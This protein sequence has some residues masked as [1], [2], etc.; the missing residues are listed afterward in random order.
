VA[1]WSIFVFILMTRP[2]DHVGVVQGWISGSSRRKL[3]PGRYLISSALFMCCVVLQE[4]NDNCQKRP[5]LIQ[6]LQKDMR[7]MYPG[8]QP[9]MRSMPAYIGQQ[10]TRPAFKL[11]SCCLQQLHTAKSCSDAALPASRVA[12]A[13]RRYGQA[14]AVSC[15]LLLPSIMHCHQCWYCWY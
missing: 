3:L 12:Q 8:V 2:L 7:L 5:E 10:G 1:V 11:S 4:K 13:G 6:K 15:V 9:S 14:T